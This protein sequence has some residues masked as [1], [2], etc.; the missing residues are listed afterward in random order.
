MELPIHVLFLSATALARTLAA[1]AGLSLFMTFAASP[2]W[3]ATTATGLS[4]A[5]PATTLAGD[6]LD[7][8][9][10][11]GGTTDV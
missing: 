3:T 2:A 11:V 8:T 4:P 5:A 10:D 1:G 6:A 9:I 7:L